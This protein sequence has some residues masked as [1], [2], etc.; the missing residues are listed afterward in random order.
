MNVRRCMR[1]LPNGLAAGSTSM[2]RFFPGTGRTT[3]RCIC[4]QCSMKPLEKCQTWEWFHALLKIW[5]RAAT[6][7]FCWHQALGCMF[8]NRVWMGTGAAFG[9]PQFPVRCSLLPQDARCCKLTERTGGWKKAP[10]QAAPDTHWSTGNQPC[11]AQ[12]VV[13][14]LFAVIVIN[15]CSLSTAVVL[16]EMFGLKTL[17]SSLFTVCRPGSFCDDAGSGLGWPWAG[18]SP[19]A[20]AVPEASWSFESEETV[21]S[22]LARAREFLDLDDVLDR[23]WHHRGN[24]SDYT[25]FG[26]AQIR[27]FEGLHPSLHSTLDPATNEDECL[28]DGMHSVAWGGAMVFE[29]WLG[30]LDGAPLTGCC[31]VCDSWLVVA[32]SVTA[33]VCWYLEQWLWMF[34]CSLSAVHC[35]F[36]CAVSCTCEIS[37]ARTSAG[38]DAVM[39]C[40]GLSYLYMWSCASLSVSWCIS[41]WPFFGQAA[42]FVP[43]LL[44]RGP[45]SSTVPLF[46]CHRHCH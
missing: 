18:R 30:R 17:P 39:G 16:S 24:T 6:G 25:E 9:N 5:W 41:S 42:F 19:R 2:T 4:R 1:P 46:H 37:A 38:R 21:T 10:R 12:H 8:S 7:W 44:P 13:L 28:F 22:I 15:I 35:I 40:D 31:P 23:P 36:S 29:R 3:S 11:Y 20:S 45:R 14:K 34:H 26:H 43:V 27:S 33:A 32:Q